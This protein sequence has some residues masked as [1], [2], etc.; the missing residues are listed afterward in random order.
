[1]FLFETFKQAESYWRK[2]NDKEFWPSIQSSQISQLEKVF[3]RP[4]KYYAIDGGRWPPKAMMRF[5]WKDRTVLVTVGVAP[6]PQPNVEMATE[7]VGLKKARA[8]AVLLVPV[9]TRRS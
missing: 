4:S 1:M 5:A 2:W 7:V 6:R 9:Q 3:G 8:S